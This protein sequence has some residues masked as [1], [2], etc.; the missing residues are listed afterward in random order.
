M[1]EILILDDEQFVRQS[2]VD[3]FEDQMWQ[4]V[5]A[6]SGEEAL[7]LLEKGVHLKAAI[8]DI[9]LPGMD[10]NEFIR[11]AY[12]RGYTMAFVICSGSPEY[13][14]PE[15]LQALPNVCNHL[16][17]KP[18]AQLSILEDQVNK[19]LALICGYLTIFATASV[20]ASIFAD[21]SSIFSSELFSSESFLSR[22]NLLLTS[23]TRASTLCL[24]L[25]VSA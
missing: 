16:F 14:V 5:E 12:K 15:D 19:I 8:V 3:F 9:R 25:S 7:E 2:F 13:L 4:I 22:P 6:R 17:K 23:A 21:S 11:E 24:M 20:K 10:G 18:V 1:K